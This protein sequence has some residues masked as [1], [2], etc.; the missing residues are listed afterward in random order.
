[1]SEDRALYLRENYPKV[2]SELLRPLL[3]VFTAAREVCDGDVDKFLILLVL[4]MRMTEHP[5]F[6]R[7]S[8]SAIMAGEPAVLPSLGTN[9]RSIAASIGIPKETAR[10]KLAEL[11]HSGWLVRQHWDFRLTAKG[12]AALEPVRVRIQAMAISQHDLMSEFL[13]A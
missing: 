2:A 10:R 9:T 11:V 8:H 3:N 13:P 7:M 5:D 6:K 12:Y 1:L 4:G